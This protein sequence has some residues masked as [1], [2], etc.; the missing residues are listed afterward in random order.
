MPERS[1]VL[2]ESLLNFKVESSWSKMASIGKAGSIEMALQGHGNIRGSGSNNGVSCCIQ[3]GTAE[4]VDNYFDYWW[5][6]RTPL[7]MGLHCQNPLVIGERSPKGPQ[8][9]STVA[10]PSVLPDDPLHTAGASNST[11]PWRKRGKSKC[12]CLLQ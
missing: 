2:H 3:A 5:V 1:Q 9:P 11:L 6:H 7:P 10:V 4:H 8:A 12:C